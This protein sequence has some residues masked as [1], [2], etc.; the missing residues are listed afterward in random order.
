MKIY[1]SLSLRTLAVFSLSMCKGSHRPAEAKGKQK[2]TESKDVRQCGSA[3]LA[4]SELQIAITKLCSVRKVNVGQVTAKLDLVFLTN[5]RR[6][7][8]LRESKRLEEQEAETRK[9]Q[10]KGV[11][12]NKYMEEPLAA[13]IGDLL[14]H[15]TAMNNAVGVSKDYLRRQC[16]AR[17]M[18]AEFDMFSYP[19]ISDRF[20]AKNKKRKIKL[21]PSD[22][23]NEVEYLKALVILMM[24][25]DSRRGHM[26]L[27]TRFPL[28]TSVAWGSASAIS[29]DVAWDSSR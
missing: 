14:A 20:R 26:E 12:F 2:R 1:Q 29:Q 3:L 16:N 6:A 18:R 13:T 21:T 27:G 7:D 25:A 9:I 22:D 8:A 23:Q 24:K 15:M 4:A 5:T 11:K 28:C 19:S 17:M 10:K